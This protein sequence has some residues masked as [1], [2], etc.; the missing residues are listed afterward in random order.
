MWVVHNKLS[1]LDLILFCLFWFFNR[2]ALLW[3]VIH[4]TD[5][6]PM[7]PYWKAW[8]ISWLSYLMTFHNSVL[9][10]GRF[11]LL[12][13]SCSHHNLVYGAHY[14]YGLLPPPPYIL[15]RKLEPRNEFISFSFLPVFESLLHFQV[16]ET[17]RNCLCS[18]EMCS[19]FDARYFF[20]RFDLLGACQELVVS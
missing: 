19:L 5:P 1:S 18:K 12:L 4:T 15:Y 14:V 10:S 13:S 2:A 8:R 9:L 3:I 6:Y 17:A 16:T 11:L 7:W 20:S